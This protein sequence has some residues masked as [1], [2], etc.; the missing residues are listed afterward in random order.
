MLNESSLITVLSMYSKTGGKN[1][2]HAWVA[3][4]THITSVSYI[5]M[6]VF[7]HMHSQQFLRGS[8]CIAASSSQKIHF[9]PL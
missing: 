4:A 8:P 2:K 6:Q 5:P 7:E 3:S 1:G 9:T